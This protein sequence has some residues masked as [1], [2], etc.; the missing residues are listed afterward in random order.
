MNS[1]TKLPSLAGPSNLKPVLPYEK[2][3]SEIPLKLPSIGNRVN[4]LEVGIEAAG[5][6]YAVRKVTDSK[7]SCVNE[8]AKSNSVPVFL[9]RI[10]TQM[11]DLLSLPAQRSP[12]KAEISVYGGNSQWLCHWIDKIISTR[13]YRFPALLQAELVDEVVGLHV[14]FASTSEHDRVVAANQYSS[15]VA[16]RS[17]THQRARLEL[18]RTI[19]TSQV[20]ILGETL[21]VSH[22]FHIHLR[23]IWCRSFQKL[24]MFR[25]FDSNDIFPVVEDNV[26]FRLQEAQCQYV[27]DILHSDWLRSIQE[28][29]ASQPES[30]WVGHSLHNRF[31][32]SVKCLMGLQLC[33]LLSQFASDIVAFVQQHHA[34]LFSIR[35]AVDDGGQV[36]L[37]PDPS[38]VLAQMCGLLRL[39]RTVVCSVPVLHSDM[40]TDPEYFGAKLVSEAQAEAVLDPA[41]GQLEALFM[42]HGP[43][44]KVLIDMY[45]K[46]EYIFTEPY[47][48]FTNEF[49]DPNAWKSSEKVWRALFLK[50][51]SLRNRILALSPSQVTVGIFRIQIASRAE[52]SDSESSEKYA[53]RLLAASA[54]E[55]KAA[56]LLRHVVSTVL[57]RLLQDAA[58][59]RVDLDPVFHLCEEISESPNRLIEISNSMQEAR[60]GVKRIMQV[61]KV[62]FQRLEFLWS[63]EVTIPDEQC[64][65]VL[66]TIFMASTLKS[67]LRD[68]TSRFAEHRWIVEED[69]LSRRRQIDAFVENFRRSELTHI[70]SFLSTNQ[71]GD[72]LSFLDKAV[73]TLEDTCQ[74]ASDIMAAEEQVGLPVVSFQWLDQ[75]LANV[76]LHRLLWEY[77]ANIT[78]ILRLWQKMIAV[79]VNVDRLNKTSSAWLH[80]FEKMLCEF[81]SEKACHQIASLLKRQVE[82]FSR[83]VPVLRIWTSKSLLQRHW[84]QIFGILNQET[85]EVHEV[86]I[87]DLQVWGAHK[88][89][90]ELLRIESAAAAEYKVSEEIDNMVLAWEA[91]SLPVRAVKNTGTYYVESFRDADAMLQ[92]HLLRVEQ[93]ESQRST[94]YNNEKI[95]LWGQRVATF[96][97]TIRLWAQVQSRFLKT[98]PFFCQLSFEFSRSDSDLFKKIEQHW[99]ELMSTVAEG[100]SW[101]SVSD[102]DTM[103]IQLSKIDQDLLALAP[104]LQVCL[105]LARTS[106]ARFYLVTDDEL[107]D[108]LSCDMENTKLLVKNVNSLFPNVFGVDTQAATGSLCAVRSELGESL[109]LVPFI[110]T[111]NIRREL[112]YSALGQQLSAAV[113]KEINRARKSFSASP[114]SIEWIETNREQAVIIAYSIHFIGDVER[115]LA[116][117]FYIKDVN[118]LLHLK[119]LELT[120]ISAFISRDH[121]N[122][123]GRRKFSSVVVHTAHQREILQKLFKLGETHFN[124]V[125]DFEWQRNVR[126]YWRDQRFDHEEGVDICIMHR[127]YSYGMEYLGNQKR[128]VLTESLQNEL[129]IIGVNIGL[130]VG[131][132]LIGPP[133]I[134]K[135]ASIKEYAAIFGTLCFFFRCSSDSS[136]QALHRICK[137]IVASGCWLCMQH[138][139]VLPL[140]AMTVFRSSMLSIQRALRTKSNYCDLHGEVIRFPDRYSDNSP[141]CSS[142]LIFDTGTMP[143]TLRGSIGNLFRPIFTE[144]PDVD[145]ILQVS[146]IAFGCDPERSKTLARKLVVLY[147]EMQIKI[148]RI[149]REIFSLANLL[150]SVCSSAAIFRVQEDRI[151]DEKIFV[152]LLIASKA[153]SLD[154]EELQLF[155]DTL[156]DVFH[157]RDDVKSEVEHLRHQIKGQ[158]ESAQT[159]NPPGMIV[160]HPNLPHKVRQLEEALQFYD[161][162]NVIGDVLTGKSTAIKEAAQKFGVEHTLKTGRPQHIN[163]V[164]I[165][166]KA[167]STVRL[168]GIANLMDGMQENGLF[169]SLIESIRE[170]SSLESAVSETW[171]VFDGD[172]EKKWNFSLMDLFGTTKSMQLSSGKIL[173]LPE[174][175]KIVFE[176]LDLTS[177]TPAMINNCGVI[178]I[179]QHEESWYLYISSKLKSM[180]R[181]ITSAWIQSGDT[182]FVSTLQI[183]ENMV[184][185]ILRP[186]LNFI[187]T[188]CKSSQYVISHM[189]YAMN[190]WAFFENICRQN[191]NSITATSGFDGRWSNASSLQYDSVETKDAYA[192]VDWVHIQFLFAFLWAVGSVLDAGGRK[193]FEV[194]MR[195]ICS[196]AVFVVTA[197]KRTGRKL[198][199]EFKLQNILPKT[200]SLFDYVYQDFSQTPSGWMLWSDLPSLGSPDII[201]NESLHDLIVPTFDCKRYVHLLTCML[202]SKRPVLLT[203]PP[204]VGKSFY[205]TCAIRKGT[206]RNVMR[207]SSHLCASTTA[208]LLQKL[209]EARLEIKRIG[210]LGP[211]R[212]SYLVTHV[213]DLHLP[214]CE[215]QSPLELLRQFFDRGGWYANAETVFRHVES[216][217]VIAALQT[218]D[219][220][221]ETL[222]R[223]L[224]GHFQSLNIVDLS[225]QDVRSIFQS[226]LT[227]YHSKFGFPEF[228][229]DLESSIVAASLDVLSKTRNHLKPTPLCP[230]YLFSFHDLRNVIMGMMQQTVANLEE[231]VDSSP[232]SEHLRLWVHEVLR[233]FYDRITGRDDQIW[234]LNMIKEVIK[235][236]MDQNFDDLF[237]HLDTNKSGD[238]DSEELRCLFFGNY[239]QD[240]G[241]RL[242]KSYDEV[243]DID[244]MLNTIQEYSAA[245]DHFSLVPMQLV[246]TNFFAE[247]FSRVS[248]VLQI[249]GGNLLLIGQ[250]GAGK[251]SLVKLAVY[252]A[253]FIL[254]EFDNFCSPKSWKD[255]L[256]AVFCELFSKDSKEIVL[257]LSSS[258]IADEQLEDLNCILNGVEIP[259]L[260][261]KAEFFEFVKILETPEFFSISELFEMKRQSLR[262][263]ICLDENENLRDLFARYPFLINRFTIDWI[264]EW[265]QE[266]M[267]EFAA[268]Y[269]GKNSIPNNM[270][271]N[272][273]VP[274]WAEICASLF[275]IARK[276][277][278]GYNS[279]VAKYQFSCNSYVHFLRLFT[280]IATKF[281]E[282]RKKEI[283]LLENKISIIQNNLDVIGRKDLDLDHEKTKIDSLNKAEVTAL[284]S[285]EAIH[286]RIEDLKDTRKKTTEDLKLCGSDLKD[287]EAI[288]DEL[289]QSLAPDWSECMKIINSVSTREMSKLKS[290]LGLANFSSACLQTLALAIFALI[291]GKTSEQCAK[292]KASTIDD[293]MVNLFAPAFNMIS[294]HDFKNRIQSLSFTSQSFQR[295]LKLVRADY[296]PQKDFNA[297]DIS[298]ACSGA[299]KI[300]QWIESLISFQDKAD[301]ILGPTKSKVAA[302]NENLLKL[303]EDISKFDQLAKDLESQIDV[304][305]QSSELISLAR[306]EAL[307]KCEKIQIK[308]NLASK[309]NQIVCNSAIH[310]PK[311]WGE[312]LHYLEK[313]ARCLNVE[314]LIACASITYFGYMNEP[315]QEYCSTLWMKYLRDSN[316]SIEMDFDVI[317]FLADMHRTS[318]MADCMACG[319]PWEERQAVLNIFT[320]TL[321]ERNHV[322]VDRFGVAYRW[323]VK[324]EADKSMMHLNMH[325]QWCDQAKKLRMAMVEG[326]PVLIKGFSEITHLAKK[327]SF[328][329]IFKEGKRFQYIGGELVCLHPD[330]RLYM[331]SETPIPVNTRYLEYLN[332]ISL[333]DFNFRSL[334]LNACF[335]NRVIKVKAPELAQFE[336]NLL[337][338]YAKATRIMEMK[339][340][341]SAL[342]RISS[343][344]ETTVV[345]LEDRVS[346]WLDARS[347]V[348]DLKR[349]LHALNDRLKMMSVLIHPM[350]VAFQCLESMS[351]L[352]ESY[353]I[354][355]EIFALCALRHINSGEQRFVQPLRDSIITRFLNS[356]EGGMN[357]DVLED[358]QYMRREFQALSKHVFESI[359]LENLRSLFDHHHTAYLF[360]AA[361]KSLLGANEVS[362]D[363]WQHFL[364]NGMIAIPLGKEV[365][366]TTKT[367]VETDETVVFGGFGRHGTKNIKVR[368]PESKPP[369][370]WLTDHT[371]SAADRLSQVASLCRKLREESVTRSIQSN[372]KFWKDYIENPDP[373]R[374]IQEKGTGNMFS[375]LSL[376]QRLLVLR[377][378]HPNHLLHGVSCFLKEFYGANLTEPLPVSIESLFESSDQAIPLFIFIGHQDDPSEEIEIFAKHRGY[379]QR[380]L[381]YRASFLNKNPYYDNLLHIIN[382]A[383]RSGQWVLLQKFPDTDHMLQIVMAVSTMERSKCNKDFRLWITT[384]TPKIPKEILYRCMRAIWTAPS[385]IRLNLIRNFMSYP[386]TDPGFF[387]VQQNPA[388]FKRCLFTI[389]FLNATLMER[390]ARDPLCWNSCVMIDA[391][392]LRNGLVVIREILEKYPNLSNKALQ[393]VIS[394]IVY[395]KRLGDRFDQTIM[396]SMISRLF[397]EKTLSLGCSFDSDGIFFIPE[398]LQRENFLSYSI[399]LPT[400]AAAEHLGMPED[401]CFGLIQPVCKRN[402]LLA[403]LVEVEI[404]SMTS[405]LINSLDPHPWLSDAI[406][407]P[408]LD[409]VLSH[410]PGCLDLKRIEADF[411]IHRVE[412]CNSILHQ[413]SYCYN[414]LLTLISTSLQSLK[415]ALAGSVL[416]SNDLE[417]L[418]RDVY[419]CRF[420]EMW[421]KCMF[422]THKSLST[423]IIAVRDAVSYFGKW[424]RAGTPIEMWL[425]AFMYPQTLRSATM[426][427]F[428]RHM[429]VDFD[430]IALKFKVIAKIPAVLHLPPSSGMYLTGIQLCR[431]RWDMINETLTDVNHLHP[432]SLPV[433]HMIPYL[434]HETEPSLTA[435]TDI[436]ECPLYRMENLLHDSLLLDGKIENLIMVVSLPCMTGSNL[437]R[438]MQLRGTKLVLEPY[439]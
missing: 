73:A 211:A 371:W 352:H 373:V 226:C 333:M 388:Y 107:A 89:C 418:A 350:V 423:K 263:I 145:Y 400:V 367:I 81:P 62:L 8:A 234:F 135:S 44:L 305:R 39:A 294:N 232:S 378:F 225:E 95:A 339:D 265:S 238:V 133:G 287:S 90:E 298:R 338:A 69:L 132:A 134:G 25:S 80:D 16:R 171:F 239:M 385:S 360:L 54:L 122:S 52:G 403:V 331:I 327:L 113:S 164:Y 376:F 205:V 110:P 128:L 355:Y 288:L 51:R 100:P 354:G 191:L 375:N 383:M 393:T 17:E 409:E 111:K 150:R 209:I 116:G 410:L 181:R 313:H 272:E 53:R 277:S 156:Q 195:S 115:A 175:V 153:P 315:L 119:E 213:E 353:E 157:R 326:L 152:H 322:A 102:D 207:L 190:L 317:D 222:P 184:I 120:R 108:I 266:A 420:P 178:S 419:N 47:F 161:G 203:G 210:V 70:F 30:K 365:S 131:G 126:L 262:V 202:F 342:D 312:R 149:H 4:Q 45:R 329:V 147:Q 427:N 204:A 187:D 220:S 387:F 289:Q 401:L 48:E 308:A 66:A 148:Y 170:L 177:S 437:P 337:V 415:E 10:Q 242:N 50:T 1:P 264:S 344:D 434:V 291:E 438:Q 369:Y 310:L 319:F 335:L 27:R 5:T 243:Q 64:S 87:G 46:F 84:D 391:Y 38:K 384:E 20:K 31:L 414:R 301:R 283:E 359:N 349:K 422:P 390:R 436:F 237:K 233:V 366:G 97:D 151:F 18:I 227:W 364:T 215:C 290:L 58:L 274:N 389:C 32:A 221:K 141:I 139:Q 137:G 77:A 346:A 61:G 251:R 117:H 246:I 433:L 249:N 320:L 193:K 162:V 163:L 49:T 381:T 40:S 43:P 332:D 208:D 279:A 166:P 269:F 65:F 267:I 55:S 282:S 36:V 284:S 101:K 357:E 358:T 261:S 96:Q 408:K 392:D 224:L 130:R 85:R 428:L 159:S 104:S 362:A 99:D 13:A 123:L 169:P 426:S 200:G 424:V 143:N 82:R 340:P 112:W 229:R 250:K 245:Y 219:F 146:L 79:E 413:E 324:K 34:P 188:E 185:H 223:R 142:F 109:E 206:N 425:P 372:P 42:E 218:Y 314:C 230:Q 406:M 394:T 41:K 136:M 280:F 216:M 255:L 404:L 439:E 28:L 259:G 22:R 293:E 121:M 430:K 235:E 374:E 396:S 412:S 273:N 281:A 194:F 78:E 154:D 297:A 336:E 7:K 35:L 173:V 382:G 214:L 29:F 91:H 74:R 411:A 361:V 189:H 60:A 345:K 179:P 260:F 167:L 421:Y 6:L 248:R 24:S 417:Q 33:Q 330:F 307:L 106:C 125:E 395:G 306:T 2:H 37:D 14:E 196:G 321:S 199:H 197:E 292:E 212:D 86:T 309:I 285:K 94:S 370:E 363:E 59:L 127:T 176:T 253:R 241:E 228:I 377:V 276:V 12:N 114:T 343:D 180:D 275:M 75:T 303:G 88:V 431:G 278:T 347:S 318:F 124:G 72:Y 398:F 168:F 380:Y 325:D 198:R 21:F 328:R 83:L 254:F 334:G 129:S 138:C 236:K 144:I 67:K 186:C 23:E 399:S 429:N 140:E 351:S 3:K 356:C 26:Y 402:D 296:I 155:A 68:A 57:D 432:S 158:L 341:L 93:L 416:L 397:S 92:D 71:V 103:H 182:N 201:L 244:S 295:G 405:N 304:S 286:T 323:I 268:K 231:S 348:M 258:E 56:S 271:D 252:T 172:I 160:I 379:A 192:T 257:L 386:V 76:K 368:S 407:K 19:V 105:E 63:L 302:L 15:A 435:G 183:L 174:K 300:F 299:E 11:A 98:L 311:D 316:I 256:K 247:H 240:L 165:Y 217:H 270:T 9:A 118:E